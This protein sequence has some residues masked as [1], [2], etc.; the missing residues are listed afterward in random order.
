MKVPASIR[1]LYDDQKEV[2]DSLG[3]RVD[4]LLKPRLQSRWHYESRLKSIE[5]F[6]L[7]I[8]SGRY[9][10]PAA[11]E[12]FFAATVVVRNSTEIAEA[13]SIATGLFSAVQR[14]PKKDGETQKG[15]EQFPFDDLRLYVSWKDDPALPSTGLEK[16]VFEL[17]IK[18]YL[19]HAW[20][21]A[22]HDLIYKS[23]DASWSKARIAYQ[24][25]AMLEHAEVSIE[26]AARLSESAA[27]A[28]SDTRTRTIRKFVSL[29]TDLWEKDDLPSDVRRLAENV[30]YL[31]Q[32]AKLQPEDLMKL[33]SEDR[34]RGGGPLI[35]NLTPYGIVL[36][37][38]LAHRKNEIDDALANINRSG[39]KRRAA[40]VV[41][42]ELE[43][44][45]DVDMN[46]WAPGAAVFVK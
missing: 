5:A 32:L 17:Q 23:D 35:R 18:T 44:P 26:E 45:D 22:T 15:P 31:A 24:I 8:E 42:K 16:V 6:T 3:S 13:E 36:Q 10:D 28:K 39:G 29:L 25:K 9:P 37:I 1:A 7:K 34:D 30:M 21:I 40:I 20:S 14:R 4:S 27:L 12:D 43:I 46:R 19:Q 38:L 2:C 33:L 11:L 41:S